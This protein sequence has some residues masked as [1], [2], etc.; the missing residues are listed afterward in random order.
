MVSPVINTLVQY[1]HLS[2]CNARYV[3]VAS[4]P[5]SA[6]SLFPTLCSLFFT[7][8]FC[9]VEEI[10]NYCILLFLIA[11][12]RP[13]HAYHHIVYSGGVPDSPS[14]KP[15]YSSRTYHPLTTP[16]PCGC[17]ELCISISKYQLPLLQ[18]NPVCL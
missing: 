15:S 7:T 9:G 5:R 16:T 3:Y 14:Q 2:C 1:N 10:H 4:Y 8:M 17:L 13:G 12:V 6:S 11:Y 18:G